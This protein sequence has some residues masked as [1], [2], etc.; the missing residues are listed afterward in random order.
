M[1]RVVVL[2]VTKV[3]KHKS[4]YQFLFD[5][6]KL[7]GTRFVFSFVPLN[8]ICSVTSGPIEFALQE[9]CLFLFSATNIC[10]RA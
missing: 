7:E 10:G 1:K 2:L 3:K 4:M 5:P 9:A 8:T 6:E